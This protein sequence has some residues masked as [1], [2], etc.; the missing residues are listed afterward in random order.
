M[1]AG[2]DGIFIAMDDQPRAD[3][4]AEAVAEFDHLFELVSRI[5]MKKRKRQRPG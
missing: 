5:D 1:R 3:F 2:R 4:F